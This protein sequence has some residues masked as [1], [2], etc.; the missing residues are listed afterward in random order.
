M[1]ELDVSHGDTRYVV[2][3]DGDHS[4]FEIYLCIGS[5]PSIIMNRTAVARVV[6]ASVLDWRK[7]EPSATQRPLLE[8]M[9]GIHFQ[10]LDKE[11]DNDPVDLFLQGGAE[12]KLSRPMTVYVPEED[13]IPWIIDTVA[14]D[15]KIV[16]AKLDVEEQ[17]E[18]REMW[19]DLIVKLEDEENV[20]SLPL[21]N[22]DPDE[23]QQENRIR[24]IK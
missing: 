16:I 13:I 1:I 24:R 23:Y 8:I 12:I 15:K 17:V 10:E 19:D 9:R 6:L 7:V 14:E 21:A 3:Q 22:T 18:L 2:F 11:S 4:E 5:A 20:A